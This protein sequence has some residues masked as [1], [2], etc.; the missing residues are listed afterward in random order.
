VNLS[1]KSISNLLKRE[2]TALLFFNK[3]EIERNGTPSSLYRHISSV[4]H[5]IRWTNGGDKPDDRT[6]PVD[7]LEL[8][9]G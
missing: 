9:L 4:P 7:L 1:V 8:P 3:G 6:A 2:A 5:I